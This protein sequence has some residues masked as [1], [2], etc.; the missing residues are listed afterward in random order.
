MRALVLTPDI[1]TRGGI[2][3]YTATLASALGELIGPGNVH[4]LPLLALGGSG[5]ACAKYQVL[6]PITTRLTASSKLRFAGKALTLGT[7]KYDLTVCTHIGLAPVAGLLRKLFETPFWVTCHGREAWPPFAK[8]VRWAMTQADLILPI[9]RFTAEMVSKVNGVPWDKMR[10]LYNAIPDDLA[11]MLMPSGG[12]SVATVPSNGKEKHILSVGMVSRENAYKGYDTVIR[13]LPLVLQA[14]PDAHYWIVGEGNDLDRLKRLADEMEVRSHVEFKGGVSDA[15][16]VACY[17]SCDVF[18]LP[19]RTARHN[20]G[21]LGEGFG[22]VYVEAALAGKPVIGSRDGGAAEAILHGETGL[23]V[24][25]TSVMDVASALIKLL[26]NPGLAVRMGY[27]GQRWAV[28]NFTSGALKRQLEVLLNLPAADRDF[29]FMTTEAVNRKG[30][31]P[32]HGLRDQARID[33][34]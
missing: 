12:T 34:L 2:A 21:W 10:V 25:P 1:Y 4:V 18:V 19:S 7:H 14:I 5:E 15:E 26:C 11:E 16:L 17:R 29:K 30:L 9:S 8:D 28:E 24:N 13:A 23:L 6:K 22:R 27:E 33:K 20:G 32:S 31:S 3:R